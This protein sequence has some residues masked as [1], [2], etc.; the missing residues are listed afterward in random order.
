MPTAN[1]LIAERAR[2]AWERRGGHAA[3]RARRIAAARK[4]REDFL[5]R[6]GVRRV[7]IT[8]REVAPVT[9][10]I[11]PSQRVAPHVHDE[12]RMLPRFR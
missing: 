10:P 3:D 9:R 2:L 1:Q 12:H 5:A 6:P 7:Q 8:G 11:Q 4:R